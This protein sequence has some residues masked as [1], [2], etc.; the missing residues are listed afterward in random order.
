MLSI[1]SD[2]HLVNVV[3]AS[4]RGE[5]KEKERATGVDKGDGTGMAR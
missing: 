2:P 1:T 3:N 5:K 4:R